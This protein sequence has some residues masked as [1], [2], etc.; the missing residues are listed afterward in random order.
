MVFSQVIFV[1]LALGALP[2]GDNKPQKEIPSLFF[3]ERDTG[4][5]QQAAPDTLA[6]TLGAVVWRSDEEWSFWVNDQ[7]VTPQLPHP[8]FDV[9]SVTSREVIIV[10]H[11]TGVQ[12]T[13]KPGKGVPIPQ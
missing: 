4:S 9:V 10:W 3:P 7:R 1:S 5:Q 6:L 12:E 11:K 13:L 2:A 8:L